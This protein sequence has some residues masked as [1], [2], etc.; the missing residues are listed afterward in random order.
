MVG[1]RIGACVA[2]Q[3]ALGTG[4]CNRCHTESTC[5]C[6]GATS[7]S[8]TWRAVHSVTAWKL[9]GMLTRMLC[10]APGGIV[11]GDSWHLCTVL[12]VAL[13]VYLTHAVSRLH[14]REDYDDTVAPFIQQHRNAF[15]DALATSFDAFCRAASWVASR[16]FCVD[17]WHGA[18]WVDRC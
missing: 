2:H 6:T 12:P 14:M 1:R 15:P 11:C 9:I 3:F 16:A 5:Q 13:F 10:C 8:N 4:T 17:H 7:S 18:T